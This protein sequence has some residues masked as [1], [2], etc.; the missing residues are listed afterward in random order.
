M[1]VL[2]I[3]NLTLDKVGERLRVGGSGYYGGRALAAYLD[4]ETYILTNVDEN[5]RGLVLG[6]L[7]SYGI[8]V[9]EIKS[10]SMPI[11]IINSGKAVEFQGTSSKISKEVIES[12]LK[13]GEFN[14]V[15]IAPI[16]RETDIDS[17]YLII[18]DFS[19]ST[20]NVVALDI[21]GFVRNIRDNR[22]TCEWI[23]GLELMLPYIDIVHGNI[24]EFCFA[25][26]EQMVIK[27]IKELST[28]LDT[29]FLVSLDVRGTYL[30]YSGEVLYIPS[31]SVNTVDEV[32]AGDVLL[33]VTSYYRARNENILSSSIKG[34]I[35][36][37]LKVENAY[38]DWF[39]RE[40]IESIAQ[41]HEK[42]IK[43]ISI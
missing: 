32:G 14:I 26:E 28:T 42:M 43:V 36:A 33:A 3:G 7:N 40:T 21:Q 6:L 22:I 1:R 17:I 13:M 16:M 2:Y 15:I 24:K 38:R 41:S 23:E 8:K 19:R 20:I 5:Y 34:I 27:S 37:S 29:A 25:K 18:E 30:V 11:F 10:N 4:V 35:A 31:L 39:D 9:F 12:Y